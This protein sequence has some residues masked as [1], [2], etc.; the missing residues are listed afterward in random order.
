M[1]QLGVVMLHFALCPECSGLSVLRSVPFGNG[2]VLVFGPSPP[3]RL[4][5]VLVTLLQY[6]G[7]YSL[8]V[9]L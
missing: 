6:S 4:P 2:F 1:A 9:G 3:Q 8:G 5:V 7:P